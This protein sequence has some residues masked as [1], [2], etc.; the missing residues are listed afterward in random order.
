MTSSEELPLE[1]TCRSVKEKLDAGEPLLLIDCRQPDEHAIAR[2]DGARLVPMN[3]IAGRLG[4]FEAYR[5]QEIVV[6]CH[7]G[8]RSERVANWLRGQGFLKARTMLGGIDRWA[9]EIDRSVPRY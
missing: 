6:H 3:E 1:I 7:H 8:G 9:E 2:I 4:E 5:G